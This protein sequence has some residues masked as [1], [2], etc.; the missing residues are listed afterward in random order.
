M[1]IQ[2]IDTHPVWPGTVWCQRLALLERH[3]TDLFKQKLY[4]L[5]GI[6][7]MATEWQSNIESYP[8]PQASC[9]SL[10]A[11]EETT[12]NMEILPTDAA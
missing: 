9:R 8:P 4:T 7:L 6:S 5:V 10:K 1:P 12:G 2:T 11:S 3:L